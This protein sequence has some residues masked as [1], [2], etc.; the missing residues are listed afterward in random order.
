MSTL[1]IAGGTAFF[2]K[3]Y[4]EAMGLVIE[5]RDY[6]E[7]QDEAAGR[8]LAPVARM[9]MCAETLRLTARLTRIM[10]WLLAQRAVASGEISVEDALAEPLDAFD[11]CS[12]GAEHEDIGLPPRLSEL[13][14]RSRLLYGR[15]A[16]LDALAR[17]ALT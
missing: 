1:T 7:R 13:L 3:T 17:R 8:E 10:A 12:A 2:G 15:V 16:R 11:V 4:G 6:L 5:A 14:G 9:Q